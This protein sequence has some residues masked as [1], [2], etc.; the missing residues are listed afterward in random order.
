MDILVNFWNELPLWARV[1]MRL[2]W[3][4][5]LLFLIF[6]FYTSPEGDFRYWRI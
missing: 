1:S 3:Y 2:T 6:L 5:L 4:L